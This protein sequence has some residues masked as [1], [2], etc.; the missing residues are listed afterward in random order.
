MWPQLTEKRRALLV[1]LAARCSPM[2]AA[3]DPAELVRLPTP[4][5]RYLERV[6]PQHP[7][8]IH[9]LAARQ[10]GSFSFDGKRWLPFTARQWMAPEVPGFLWDARIRMMPFVNAFVHDAYLAG[11]GILDARLFGL[12][13]LAREKPTPEL[14]QGELLRFLAETPW[15]PTA[16][17]PG[18]GVTWSEV[19]DS[20]AQA[21]LQDRSTQVSLKFHFG[22][23][24]LVDTIQADARPRLVKGK[25]VPAPWHCRF[26]DYREQ[27]GLLVPL[28][29]E[30]T[31]MLPE[32]PFPYW[33]GRL[34][35]A[36]F[37]FR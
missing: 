14:A 32:G 10:Q 2:P 36:V 3:V 19:D 26:S 34:V 9:T 21:S 22:S 20:T 8:R 25:S 18:C 1:D 35:E 29:G 30:V 11:E 13:P 6:L 17:I 31:W 27:Q 37:D 7:R 28:E 12:I 33:R 16:L 4:V 24:G 15:Y 23:D 5:R